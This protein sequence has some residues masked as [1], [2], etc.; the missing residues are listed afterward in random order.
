MLKY[1]YTIRLQIF[2]KI[3][4]LRG[5]YSVSCLPPNWLI[6]N[7]IRHYD[8]NSSLLFIQVITVKTFSH[9]ENIV[10]SKKPSEKMI[11]LINVMKMYIM[12]F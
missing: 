9:K 5:L 1:I 10:P 4:F 3:C 8:F 7:V 12:I 6:G 11:I 2:I